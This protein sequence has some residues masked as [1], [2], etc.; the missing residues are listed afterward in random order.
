L[1][2]KVENSHV[3]PLKSKYVE[4]GKIAGI[5]RI[6]QSEQYAFVVCGNNYA[7]KCEQATIFGKTLKH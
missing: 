7:V 1:R 6:K 5:K 4:C 3:S 2:K